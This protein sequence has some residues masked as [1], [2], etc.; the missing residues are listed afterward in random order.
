MHENGFKDGQAVEKQEWKKMYEKEIDDLRLQNTK[1]S[2]QSAEAAYNYSKCSIEYE[3][4]KHK[5]EETNMQL[6]QA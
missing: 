3:H 6:E 1:F 4:L 2:R 5:F